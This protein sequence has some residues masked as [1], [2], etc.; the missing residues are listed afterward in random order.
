MQKQTRREFLKT[1]P[2][3]LYSVYDDPKYAGVVTEL[4]SQLKQLRP[5]Y[6]DTTGTPV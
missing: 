2:Q 4:K 1:D 3:E 5:Q 6:H